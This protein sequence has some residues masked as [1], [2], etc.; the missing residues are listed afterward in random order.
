MCVEERIPSPVWLAP[1]I[2]KLRSDV[3]MFCC[4]GTQ[5]RTAVRCAHLRLKVFHVCCCFCHI[6]RQ[7]QI[8]LN[9][10]SITE[11]TQYLA[12]PAV[13]LLAKSFDGELKDEL[14]K[15]S[16]VAGI[17]NCIQEINLKYYAGFLLHQETKWSYF[18]IHLYSTF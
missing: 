9:H 2:P 17:Y 14:F 1:W 13:A 4:Q 10:L 12:A 18:H 6:F 3:L 7:A 15:N 5:C 8:L 16:P 11:R